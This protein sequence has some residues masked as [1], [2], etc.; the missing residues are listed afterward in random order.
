MKIPDF[1]LIVGTHA[2]FFKPSLSQQ[3]L[4]KRKSASREIARLSHRLLDVDNREKKHSS[5]LYIKTFCSLFAFR[6][7]VA[8]AR[9]FLLAFKLL[10]AGVLETHSI[11]GQIIHSHLSHENFNA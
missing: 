4:Q 8:G 5:A 7:E 10:K 6:F 11:L 1:Y 2:A 9:F 3:R